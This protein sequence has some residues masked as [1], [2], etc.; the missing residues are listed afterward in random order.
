[1]GLIRKIFTRGLSCAESVGRRTAVVRGQVMLAHVTCGGTLIEEAS[2]SHP[3][4][5]LRPVT[6]SSPVTLICEHANSHCARAKPGHGRM[7]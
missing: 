4:A 2:M 3:K 1:M 6:W 5:G 7:C